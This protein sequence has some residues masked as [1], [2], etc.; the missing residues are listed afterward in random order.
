[1]C[2]VVTIEVTSRPFRFFTDTCRCLPA[3][4]D[5]VEFRVDAGN[6]YCLPVTKARLDATLWPAIAEAYAEW[7]RPPVLRLTDQRKLRVRVRAGTMPREPA[8][9]P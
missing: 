2:R 3:P 1:M 4:I 6:T 9:H 8:Y 7:R 5:Y